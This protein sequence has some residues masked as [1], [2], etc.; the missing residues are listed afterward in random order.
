M[1]FHEG[2]MRTF[3]KEHI[4]ILEKILN[5]NGDCTNKEIKCCKCPF[6]SSN[7]RFD[8]ECGSRLYGTITKDDTDISI[9]VINKRRAQIILD[10]LRQQDKDYRIKELEKRVEEL[11]CDVK[12]L[13]ITPIDIALKKI[14]S[15]K[16]AYVKPQDTI[17]K[18]KIIYNTERKVWGSGI[19]KLYIHIG[20]NLFTYEDVVF[21]VDILNEHHI[22]LNNINEI[23][24]GIKYE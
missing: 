5:H 22:N 9:E 19:S 10:I 1:K 4:G 13:K 24:G 2:R 18:Y 3:T 14:N 21:L 7:N 12:K 23:L 6:N 15:R 17:D 16:F 11:E 20:A 8:S